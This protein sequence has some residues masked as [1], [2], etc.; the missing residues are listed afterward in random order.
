MRVGISLLG[1]LPLPGGQSVQTKFLVL[2]IPI[3]PLST[4]FCLRRSESILV[5]G[6]NKVSIE[7]EPVP[8][9]TWMGFLGVPLLISAGFLPIT[10]C[11]APWHI[12]IIFGVLCV[13]GGG[14]YAKLR[15][16]T[17]RQR[18]HHQLLFDATGLSAD[19]AWLDQ[20]L[21]EDIQK[22]LFSTD[23]DGFNERSYAA[24]LYEARVR[25]L[26]G[27][28]AGNLAL[29][30]EAAAMLTQWLGAGKGS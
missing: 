9:S 27:D 16:L 1:R 25:R 15:F 28:A 6:I 17:A 12:T 8:R 29:R 18:M 24:K 19:P 14:I 7:I 21:V 22:R 26:N 4:V 11:F 20:S 2:G 13:L 5:N 23:I 3:A 10:L 30:E